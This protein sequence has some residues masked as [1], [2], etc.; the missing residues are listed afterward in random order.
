MSWL[1]CWGVLAGLFI[2]AAA[3]AG[4]ASAPP[5]PPPATLT[6]GIA[7]MRLAAELETNRETILRFIR[8]AAAPG[9]RLLIFPETSLD[10]PPQTPTADIDAAVDV[11]RRAADAADIY[12]VLGG[13]YKRTDADR[14]YERIVVIDPEG[15]IIHR[16]DKLWSDA[17]FPSVP[18]LFYVDGV[19]CSAILCADR[20]IRGV[21]DLPAVAGSQVLIECSNNYANEWLEDLGW[22]WYVPRALRNNAWVILAN[23]PRDMHGKA[24][25]GH[26]AVIAPDGRLAA[27]AGNEADRLLMTT[28]NLAEATRAEA[29]RRRDHPAFRAYWDVGLRILRGEAVEVALPDAL[30][31]PAVGVALAAAQMAC[32]R[33]ITEN[34]ARIERRVQ[35]ARKSGADLV[36][37]PELAVTGADAA[38]IRR[39]DTAALDAALARIRAVARAEG[40]AVAVGMPLL[41]GG[42]RQNGAVVVGPD[43]NV[44]TQYAQ[45]VVDRPDLF[46]AGTS[47]RAMWFRVK[48]VPAVVTVGR[49]A[50][51]SEIAELAAVRGAQVHV[52]LAYDR[53]ATPEGLLR[54]RQVW[55]NLA[56]FRTFTATVNAADP[57]GVPEPSLPAGGGS[58]LWEDFRRT[59]SR[60][61][62]QGYAP[63]S[64]VRLAEAG[65]GDQVLCAAHTIAAANPYYRT[66]TEKTNPQMKAWYDA[67]AR[68]IDAADPGQ[69]G[70]VP[71]LRTRN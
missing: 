9:C 37:F 46:V 45:L 41:D 69:E 65:R 58:A 47:T 28:I 7:Q 11:I 44:L 48:G 1:P 21:E 50:L 68:V 15:R 49:D 40:V 13:K 33:S 59:R 64:A 17:R 4:E 56:S 16:Y 6:L 23:T 67:G 8:D 3:G 34:L 53:D 57:A 14:P 27:A 62:P 18:G 19:P 71:V 70:N 63:Y 52:H 55:A 22:Y 43:G 5:G 25:H 2:V 60:G 38:D 39:A 12:V 20:W 31:S 54:R 32:S 51:W 30:K 24:G 36:A 61:G 66:L 26:S 29:L 35:D 10:S 42:R